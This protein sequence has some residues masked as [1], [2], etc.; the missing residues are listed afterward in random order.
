MSQAVGRDAAERREL[1]L[2]WHSYSNFHAVSVLPFG[3]ASSV[4]S[5]VP[6]FL[7]QGD[8]K[9]VQSTKQA[10]L[11][12]LQLSC[13]AAKAEMEAFVVIR[14]S[15]CGGV[16]NWG[17]MKQSVIKG[18]ASERGERRGDV[19]SQAACSA[20]LHGFAVRKG[21]EAKLKATTLTF[22]ADF[23]HGLKICLG[24]VGTTSV[25][26][27][28]LLFEVS[29]YPN[30]GRAALMCATWSFIVKQ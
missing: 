15:M 22:T 25:T 3:S 19:L 17:E 1:L 28:V 4:Q 2:F 26:S 12:V 13:F 14:K 23:L 27:V 29:L 24:E 30:I 7:D 11:P 9:W 21:L 20:R 5:A 8:N 10:P 16:C 6:A 18:T